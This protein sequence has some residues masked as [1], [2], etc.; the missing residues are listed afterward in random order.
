M[1]VPPANLP[2]P[3]DGKVWRWNASTEQWLLEDIPNWRDPKDQPVTPAPRPGTDKGYVVGGPDDPIVQTRLRRQQEEYQRAHD[4]WLVTQNP[5]LKAG[6]VWKPTTPEP[7]PA[8]F[9]DATTNF[10]PR[11]TQAV[12]APGVASSVPRTAQNVYQGN[13]PPPATRPLPGAQ[14]S[15]WTRAAR[16]GRDVAGRGPTFSWKPKAWKKW[17]TKRPRV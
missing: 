14:P 3:P 1:P 13:V 16:A 7:K 11:A 2:Q 15:S 5:V 6:E 10:T 17:T 8:D 12:P 4:A 9:I